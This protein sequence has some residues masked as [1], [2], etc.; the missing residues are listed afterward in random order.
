MCTAMYTFIRETL[1]TN[2]EPTVVLFVSSLWLLNNN[3]F[4]QLTHDTVFNE[5][6]APT[7]VGVDLLTNVSIATLTGRMVST[8]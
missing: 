7:T 2:R 8:R 5:M 1:M 6:T 3:T 4:K